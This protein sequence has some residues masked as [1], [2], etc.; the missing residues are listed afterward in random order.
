MTLRHVE[1]VMGTVFSIVVEA[2]AGGGELQKTNK[3]DKINEMD[4]SRLGAGIA[5]AVARLHAIDAKFS[6]YREDS[7][8][9]R[10]ARGESVE[11]D[12]EVA[13]VLRRCAEVEA[14]TDGAFTAY[15]AG[16]LDPSGWVKGWAIEEVDRILRE[17]GSR[18][19][20]IVGGG[21]V[22]AHGEPGL[23]RPWTVG[24]ADPRQQD[25]YA[26]LVSGRDFAVATSGTAERGAHIIDPATAE[27]ATGF[28]SV[29]LIGT[30]IA[31]TDAYATAVFAMGPERG[32]E[33]A[34]ERDGIEAYAVLP[35]GRTVETSGFARFLVG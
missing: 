8:I 2:G 31:R 35:D 18:D 16:R 15:P 7:A 33:W 20:L 24:I 5:T 12:S 29:T 25:R 34:Q 28:A 4:E 14:D 22:Q 21:D 27:P 1:P 6:T 9:S 17:A 3:I 10:M 11:R 26:A 23:G 32:L 30:R 19:H 13:E